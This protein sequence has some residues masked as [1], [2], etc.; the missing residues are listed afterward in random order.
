MEIMI[1]A[2]RVVQMLIRLL[3]LIIV[4]LGLLFWTGNAFT[5]LPLHMLLGLTLVL[6]LWTMSGLALRAGV[7]P[8]RVA[9][10][11]VWG[12][13]VPVFG[14]VQAQLLPGPFHWIVQVAHLLIGMGA[15]GQAEDLAAR[16][17]DRRASGPAG[18][19]RPLLTS[20]Q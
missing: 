13:I 7:A 11:I 16:I 12:V 20:G 9:L 14:L 19:R 3:G 15:I 4:T 5:L 10:A 1:V 17:R 18:Q 2:T 6:L 8:W